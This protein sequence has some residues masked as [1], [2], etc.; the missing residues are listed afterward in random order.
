VHGDALLLGQV[1]RSVLANAIEAM[2]HD[3]QIVVRGESRGGRDG[4]TLSIED[5]GP[6]MTAAQLARVGKPFFTT[7]PRGLGIGLALARRVVERFGGRIEIDSRAGAGTVVRL[8]LKA[9]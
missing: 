9:A 2:D 4:V 6:G 5:S 7:K 8:H 1:L 3:G